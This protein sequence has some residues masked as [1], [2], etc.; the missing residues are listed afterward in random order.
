MNNIED[1]I[2]SQKTRNEKM[3]KMT[4][5]IGICLLLTLLIAFSAW[6]YCLWE[7]HSNMQEIIYSH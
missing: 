1:L 3:D 2:R 7:Y 4:K 6:G 5:V